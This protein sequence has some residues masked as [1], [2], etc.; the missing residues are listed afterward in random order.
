LFSIRIRFKGERKERH[1]IKT[2]FACLK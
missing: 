2:K 1:D